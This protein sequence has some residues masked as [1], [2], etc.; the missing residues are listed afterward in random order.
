CEQ[1]PTLAR[2]FLAGNRALLQEKAGPLFDELLHHHDIT[3]L[4]FIT[5]DRACFLR[6]HNPPRYGDR[7]DRWTMDRAIQSGREAHGI[8]LGPLGTFTLRVVK[9]WRVD[10]RLIGYLEL[11]REITHFLPIL[12]EMLDADIMFLVQKKFLKRD[13]W[14][15]GMRMLGH[16]ENW[17]QLSDHVIIDRTLTDFPAALS[18]HLSPSNASPT[19][20]QLAINIAGRH[21][22][23]DHVSLRDS[24]GQELGHIV[25][26]LDFNAQRATLR[27]FY[28]LLGLAALGATVALIALFN[29]HIDR[30]DA[31]L[32]SARNRLQDELL[33]RERLTRELAENASRF[34]NLFHASP[35][36]LAENDFSPLNDFLDEL[37][38]TG[39][40]ELRD[41]LARQPEMKRQCMGKIRTNHVNQAFLRLFRLDS[42]EEIRR[43][44]I[45]LFT[46]QAMDDFMEAALAI[47]EGKKSY[48]AETT[49][50]TADGETRHILIHVNVLPGQEKVL[51]KVLVS[52]LDITDSK[53][54]A[55]ALTESEKKYRQLVENLNEG[56]WQTDENGYTTFVNQAMAEM[57]GYPAGQMLG[58]HLF[59]F[60][61]DRGIDLCKKDAER[62]RQG[63]STTRDCQLLTQNGRRI[64]TTL[65]VAPLIDEN[66][67]YQGT[68]AGVLD[69]TSRKM[70]ERALAQAKVAAE[71]ANRA[72][73]QFLAN[74]SHEIR[75]PM[76]GIIGMTS[77]A[78]TTDL[79]ME[80]R[81][82]LSIIHDSATSLL[83]IINDILD[84]SKIE[85]GQMILEEQPFDLREV[86]EN[87]LQPVASRAQEKGLELLYRLP[88]RVPDQLLGDA[89]RLRQILLNLVGNGVKFTEEGY[90]LVEVALIHE[91]ERGAF[92]SFTVKDT[93]IG[94]PR[95]KQRTIFNSFTQ[96]DNTVSRLYGGT[97]LGLSICCKLASLMGGEIWVDS[98]P[99]RGS[100]FHVSAR[101]GKTMAEQP[102][103]AFSDAPDQAAVLMVDEL[104]ASRE[105][106]AEQL[107]EWGFRTTTAATGEEAAAML[108]R[109]AE[110]GA[111]PRVVLVNL[112]NRAQSE[113]NM[114]AALAGAHQLAVPPLVVCSVVKN[115][116]HQASYPG[117]DIRTVLPKPVS[118]HELRR[119]LYA[120][121]APVAAGEQ[122]PL[123]P[124]TPAP[125]PVE[126][127]PS[128]RVLLVEDNDINRELAQ[129]VL[130]RGGHRVTN[131]VNG[132]EALKVL[133][134]QRFDVILM[135]VQMPELDGLAASR[136]IR[137][138]ERGKAGDEG[139]EERHRVIM[140][141]AR[142]NLVNTRTPIVAMTA[143]AM[144]GDKEECLAAGMDH[145]VTK[146]FLAEEVL[147]VLLQVTGV[148]HQ[149][150][151][152]APGSAR[153]APVAATAARPSTLSVTR[154]RE[155]MVATYG[156]EEEK[157]DQLLHALKANLAGYLAA[158]ATAADAENLPALRLAAHSIK[159][160]LLNL[161]IQEG[162]DLAKT[163][164]QWAKE[165]DPTAD[166]PTWLARLR[167]LLS[168][169]L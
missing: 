24:S 65:T 44:R 143:H 80:Q 33:E 83:G 73:S 120:A 75:T 85:A 169:L 30:I 21:Y 112:P 34:R 22:D 127:L 124:A 149:P 27:Q 139:L 82:Y 86:I 88:A 106:V 16:Q 157:I 63:I 67:R 7:I 108:R 131:A 111:V 166:Y 59:T 138:Y 13:Q 4:Y 43:N 110:G 90:V 161:G 69:I 165:D 38:T 79:T 41:Y 57:L 150:P 66:G 50:L 6:M 8:E 144:A 123:P 32:T 72:K 97:G 113:E 9:P 84:F 125:S 18:K 62:H 35:L 37:Q 134:E 160:L 130:E 107:A 115:L 46:P 94:I 101:F 92:L 11:G 14:E 121:L 118:R 36:G 3:H 95:E 58:S 98:E 117:L 26:L 19:L 163:L 10:G 74:M 155:H 47:H 31:R 1:D 105:I 39:V 51:N 64:I 158:A 71:T 140:S 100:A 136:L 89:M 148:Y 147:A 119:S 56:V 45:R 96:A 40:T 153:P 104:A 151:P 61:D 91:D 54:T 142:Q 109:A 70:A 99:G 103:M 12:K 145:Y 141:R 164:E 116:D 159:G 93:G 42:Q 15:E 133:G 53:R 48:R 129:I 2:A 152:P 52:I 77:L 29:R 17:D 60:L 5:P 78:L 167:D 28:F 168:P 132:V 154:V 126:E 137:C 162:A 49:V 23:A 81:H 102:A 135:D 68:V 87:T 128:L 76:N 156:L 146:P 55:E 122:R 114:L 20:R 25:L